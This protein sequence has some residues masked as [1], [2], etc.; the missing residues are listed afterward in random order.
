MRKGQRS[1][2]NMSETHTTVRPVVDVISLVVWE[3][4]GRCRK[5]VMNRHSTCKSNQFKKK[6]SMWVC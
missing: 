6:L 5:N 2:R 1:S 4:T 3:I